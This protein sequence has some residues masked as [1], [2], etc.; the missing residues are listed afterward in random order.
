[1]SYDTFIQD[2]V[3]RIVEPHTSHSMGDW[4]GTEIRTNPFG[5]GTP[6]F[7]SVQ[8]CTDCKLEQA[9]SAA[10]SYADKELLDPCVGDI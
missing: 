9:K 10:G 2:F 3:N 5:G 7:H 4:E 1:M 8:R 6:R